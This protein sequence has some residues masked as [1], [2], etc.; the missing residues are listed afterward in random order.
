MVFVSYM[1]VGW[2]LSV[3]YMRQDGSFLS[4]IGEG[5]RLA[6]SDMSKND[7]YLSAT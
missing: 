3:S 5:W 1:S 7:G 2:L 4:V 6:V